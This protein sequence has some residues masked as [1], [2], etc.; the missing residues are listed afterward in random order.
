MRC[1]MLAEDGPVV[2]PS[3]SQLVATIL[4]LGDPHRSQVHLAGR[5]FRSM[6][7]RAVAV[8]EEEAR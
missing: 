5:F 2:S 1:T 6:V 7:D 4:S 3:Y 8:H